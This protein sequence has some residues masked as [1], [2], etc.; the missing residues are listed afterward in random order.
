MAWDA[1]AKAVTYTYGQRSVKLWLGKTGAEVNGVAQKAPVAPVT[2]EGKVMIPLLFVSQGLGMS[3]RFDT[4]SGEAQIAL[5]PVVT[6]VMKNNL[7]QPANLKVPAGTVV[8]WLIGETPQHTV[9]SSL[10]PKAT[11]GPGGSFRYRFETPGTYEYVCDLHASMVGTVIVEQ[12]GARR[13]EEA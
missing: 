5:P 3:P 11:L 13:E 2:K 7:F 8:V 10:W 9:A 6:V 4:A 1:G 12:P